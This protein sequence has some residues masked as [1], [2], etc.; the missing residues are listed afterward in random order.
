LIALAL[1]L[2]LSFGHHHFNE[3]AAHDTAAL[4]ASHD[5]DHSGDGGV[6][7]HGSSVAH[8]CLA[9]IALVAAPLAAGPLV[10]SLGSPALDGVLAAT[11]SFDLRDRH[12]ASF[13]ARAPPQS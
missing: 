7:H 12:G 11:A 2:A 5:T 6:D 10:A 9:C 1:N 4:E 8:P 13:E 3:A